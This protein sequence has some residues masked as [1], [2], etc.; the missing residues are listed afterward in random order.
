[1]SVWQWGWAVGLGRAT[2]PDRSHVPALGV[3]LY[4][5]GARIR[6]S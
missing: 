4:G 2:L 5:Y 1:M 6:H 3:Q